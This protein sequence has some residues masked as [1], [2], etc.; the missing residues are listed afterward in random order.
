MAAPATAARPVPK[1]A[2]R[3]QTAALWQHLLQWH[4][5]FSRQFL[6]VL[7]AA[8]LQRGPTVDSRFLLHGHRVRWQVTGA[9]PTFQDTS[10]TCMF[11]HALGQIHDGAFSAY[12]AGSENALSNTIMLRI[13]LRF[14]DNF[15]VWRRAMAADK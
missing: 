4:D 7:K 5:K 14:V 12:A 9:T 6:L 8:Q 15:C 10:D 11:Q 3:P 1:R 2:S 13:M